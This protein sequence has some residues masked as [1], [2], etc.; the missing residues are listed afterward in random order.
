MKRIK[1]L[2]ELEQAIKANADF[3]LINGSNENRINTWT[4]QGMTL[5]NILMYID[6]KSLAYQ[7]DY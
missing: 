7:T 6:S 3:Y 5:G 2:S 4:L 1:S